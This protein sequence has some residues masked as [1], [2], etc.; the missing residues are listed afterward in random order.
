MT[1]PIKIMKKKK[2]EKASYIFLKSD[3]SG[4]IKKYPIEQGVNSTNNRF[5]IDKLDLMTIHP[6][7]K[8]NKPKTPKNAIQ[9]AESITATAILSM[10]STSQ[11]DIDYSHNW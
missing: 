7:I 10:D 8:N 1:L 3:V 5:F 6:R 9:K 4:K 2:N 11:H